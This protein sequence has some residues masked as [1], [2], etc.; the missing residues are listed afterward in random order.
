[1]NATRH[2]AKEDEGEAKDE[3]GDDEERGPPRKSLKSIA[4]Q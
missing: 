4:P 1:M 2:F 3:W